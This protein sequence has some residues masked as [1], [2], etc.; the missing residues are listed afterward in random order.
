M[1][2]TSPEDLASRSICWTTDVLHDIEA[3]DQSRLFRSTF[4][5]QACSNTRLGPRT[6]GFDS[7]VLAVEA[8]R[9]D[10]RQSGAAKSVPCPGT[11]PSGLCTPHSTSTLWH[12]PHSCTK[13]PHCMVTAQPSLCWAVCKCEGTLELTPTATGQKCLKEYQVHTRSELAFTGQE[14]PT[15]RCSN[16]DSH[17]WDNFRAS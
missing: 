1:T 6:A 14:R 15:A 10:S 3:L 8:K 2:S 7:Q 13:I 16:P 5:V 17:V 4:W 11:Q 12:M 9:K